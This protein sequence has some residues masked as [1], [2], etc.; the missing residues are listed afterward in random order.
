[1][2]PPATAAATNS[3][4]TNSRPLPRNTV[5]KNRSSCAPIRS[6]IT[7]M[8]HRKAMPANGMRFSPIATAVLFPESVSQPP[9]TAGLAG[10]GD[11]EQGERCDQEHGKDDAGDRGR[12]RR[13]QGAPRGAPRAPLG[14]LLAA[15]LAASGPRQ[16]RR[17]WHS[18]LGAGVPAR[19]Q[20]ST[21]HGRPHRPAGVRIG[22]AQRFNTGPI[23]EG[24]RGEQGRQ[25]DTAG[26]DGG[27][28]HRAGL[29]HPA[30]SDARLSR[31]E[32][33]V[34]RPQPRAHP[35]G[36]RGRLDASHR[37][38]R[39]APSRSATATTS[40]GTGSRWFP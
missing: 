5:A 35:P 26:A 22:P 20:T 36:G 3:M 29:R 11:P 4:A 15:L 7:P 8:N 23:E 2:R 10:D 17:S 18:L 30:R 32:R 9:A 1:M 31:P 33:P 37:G 28:R 13:P 27:H 14:A 21:L 40:C 24:C 39:R 38:R 25:A 19:R 16:A 6:L 12:P 34:L